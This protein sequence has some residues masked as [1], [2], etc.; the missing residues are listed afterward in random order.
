MGY[1]AHH[2]VL[3]SVP[4]HIV[5]GTYPNLRRKMPDLDAFREALPEEF[6]PLLIGPVQTAINNDY[7]IVFLPDGSKEGWDTSD[8]GDRIRADLL[9]LFADF[10]GVEVQFGGDEPHLARITQNTRSDDEDVD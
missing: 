9:T 4:G 7:T 6:R 10:A 2:A 5:K 1:I 3:I 8:R